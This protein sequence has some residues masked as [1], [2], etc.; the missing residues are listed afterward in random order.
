MNA[1]LESNLAIMQVEKTAWT[2]VLNEE[3]KSLHWRIGGV[4]LRLKKD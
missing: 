2:Q 1:A 3:L 4:V